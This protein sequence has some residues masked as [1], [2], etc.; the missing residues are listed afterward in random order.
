MNIGGFLKT[1]YSD[2]PGRLSSVI[3]TNGCN[4][5]CPY[6]HNGD[7]ARGN[8]PETET[9]DTVLTKLDQR[10]Q[11]IRAVVISGGEPTLYR[12]LPEC[13]RT[14][15]NAGYAVKL[16]TNGS[17][18]EMLKKLFRESLLD[19]IAMDFKWLIPDYA[20]FVADQALTA[21]MTWLNDSIDL[22]INSGIAHEFRTTV[23]LPY[24]SEATLENMCRCI[25]KAQAWSL[26]QY[27][28]TSNQL[29]DSRFETCSKSEL[30]AFANRQAKEF[31]KMKIRVRAKV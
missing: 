26:Q 14:L 17:N 25:G 18:P 1:S 28:Y 21:S 6:C 29:E 2:F 16:D 24:H 4:F 3:F 13:I 7:L 9:F 10:R 30:E 5:R 12:D 22:I 23:L 27:Q 19:Y 31:P 20:P 15:K 8:A 11:H